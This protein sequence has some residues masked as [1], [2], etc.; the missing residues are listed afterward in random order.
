MPD[1]VARIRTARQPHQVFILG[2]FLLYGLASVPL[3]SR[4]ATRSVKDFPEPWGRLLIA[5]LAVGSALVLFAAWRNN[6][7]AVTRFERSGHYLL[8]ILFAFYGGWSLLRNGLDS[9]AFWGVLF[10]LAG[11]SVWRLF[12]VHIDVHRALKEVAE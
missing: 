11:A 6:K 4:I 7:D 10:G 9:A 2:V 12:Q 5:G 3:Y 8:I 1:R